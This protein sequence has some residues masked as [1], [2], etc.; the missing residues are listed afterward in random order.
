M[1]ERSGRKVDEGILNKFIDTEIDCSI[2]GFLHNITEDA[3]IQVVKNRFIR[4]QVGTSRLDTRLDTINRMY[5]GSRQSTRNESS[6]TS[7]T[8]RD[9][10]T[11]ATSFNNLFEICNGDALNLLFDFLC[12]FLVG[13]FPTAAGVR[14]DRGWGKGKSFRRL[15]SRGEGNGSGG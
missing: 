1:K 4:L 15:R 3:G 5:D 8:I 10:D 11:T 13:A 14:I 12:D 7:N 6:E 2:R 9:I